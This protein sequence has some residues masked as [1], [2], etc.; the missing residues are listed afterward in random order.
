MAHVSYSELRGNLATY[1]EAVCDGRAPI[2]VT[3]QNARTVVLISEEDYEGLMETVHLL[4]SPVNAARLLR[5]INQAN[6]GKLIE[7]DIIEHK[8]ERTA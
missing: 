6:E 1:M 4:R 8:P 7:R 3:R 5:S 2:H